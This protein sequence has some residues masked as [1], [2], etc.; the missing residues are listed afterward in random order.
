MSDK[1]MSR[2]PAIVAGGLIKHYEG[3]RVRAVDGLDLTI[4]TGE[5]VSI[6]GPSGCGKTTLLNLLAAVDRPDSG[7]LTIHGQALTEMSERE[8]DTFRQ[9]TVGL[10]FQLHNLLPDLS[11]WENVQTPMLGAGFSQRERLGRASDLLERVDLLDRRDALPTV[12]S[13]GERQRVAI[14]RALA[15]R[16]SILLADE[17]TGALD[18]KSSQRLLDL[19]ND[20][21]KENGTT[22]V[23]VTHEQSIADRAG[24]TL[25][26]LDG[27]MMDEGT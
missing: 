11:A 5:F 23:V 2:T 8:I 16:P 1:T 25:N 3:G 7:T 26:M 18:S 24:R 6:C 14:A 19:L 9:K 15:N 4:D 13:G 12:L 10:V 21:Q 20:L 17:P 27:R 22:L